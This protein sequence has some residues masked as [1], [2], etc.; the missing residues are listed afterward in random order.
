MI[1]SH[2][3]LLDK[4]IDRFANTIGPFPTSL[5]TTLTSPIYTMLSNV[6]FSE[7]TCMGCAS[8]FLSLTQ[9]SCLREQRW[10]G[11]W[12]DR[13][14]QCKLLLLTWLLGSQSIMNWSHQPIKYKSPRVSSPLVRWWMRH[15]IVFHRNSFMFLCR[16]QRIRCW[17]HPQ[18]D[19]IYL[20]RREQS[21]DIT[22][23]LAEFSHRRRR[24]ALTR[25]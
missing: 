5:T 8:S 9:Y 6:V 19:R 14:D 23:A 11:P 4:R 3:R 16:A 2:G 21:S 20:L 25:R 15:R 24:L 7:S 18:H 17:R 10:A 1:I 22:P 13:S 12:R